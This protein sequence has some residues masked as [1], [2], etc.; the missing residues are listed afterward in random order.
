[1]AQVRP[2]APPTVPR[3]SPEKPETQAFPAQDNSGDTALDWEGLVTFVKGKKPMLASFLE[4]GRPLRVSAMILEI[5]FTAGSFQLSSLQDAAAMAELQ[6]LAR[7]YFQAQTNIKLVSLTEE[8][9]VAP[10]TLSEKKSLEEAGRQRLILQEAQNH[11]LV[12]AALAIFG[13]EIGEVDE[14]RDTKNK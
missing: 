8:M 14:V 12:A 10:P 4:H 11:P 7:S 6:G 1:V 13:G 3:Q 5:G 9:G 2:A